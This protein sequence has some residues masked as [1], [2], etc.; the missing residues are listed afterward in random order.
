ML[1]NMPIGMV[2]QGAAAYLMSQSIRFNDDGS[3]YMYRT[4]P[5]GGNEKTG[6]VSVWIKRCKFGSAQYILAQNNA[7]AAHLNFNA[8]DTLTLYVQEDSPGYAMNK[9]TSMKFRDNAWYHIVASW[10]STPATPVLALEVNGAT[11]AFGTDSN[12]GVVQNDNLQ[13]F[14]NIQMNASAAGTDR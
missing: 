10:D 4:I 2:S 12:N 1:H 14:A 3:A 5:A 6:T 11:P 7:Y 13:F 8:D 9:T